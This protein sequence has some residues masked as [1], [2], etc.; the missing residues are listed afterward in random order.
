[1]RM[2]LPWPV[3]AVRQTGVHSRIDEEQEWRVRDRV[4]MSAA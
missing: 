2:Q 3:A 1:M 4:S